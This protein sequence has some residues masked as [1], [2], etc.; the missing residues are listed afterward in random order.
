MQISNHYKPARQSVSF[1]EINHFGGVCPLTSN[2]DGFESCVQSQRGH[3]SSP[4]LELFSM[5]LC[6]GTA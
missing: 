4:R 6:G 5:K 3:Q 2:D 1:P